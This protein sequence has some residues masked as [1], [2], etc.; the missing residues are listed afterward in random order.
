MKKVVLVMVVLLAA[1]SLLAGEGKSCRKSDAQPVQLTGTLVCRDGDTGADCARVFR[2]A[3]TDTEYT[4]CD[5][6]K[7]KLG[8]LT[9]ATVRVTGKLVSCSDGGQELMIDK[10]VKI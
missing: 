9:G 5:K 4:V 6:S 2:V 1:G 10:A 3:N 8:S 7:A